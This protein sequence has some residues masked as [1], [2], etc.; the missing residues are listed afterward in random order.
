MNARSLMDLRSAASVP[1]G[2]YVLKM[3]GDEGRFGVESLDLRC[4]VVSG[5]DDTDDARKQPLTAQRARPT[6]VQRVPETTATTNG[7]PAP[8]HLSPHTGQNSTEFLEKTR[9]FGR[10]RAAQSGPDPV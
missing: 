2:D 3:S 10:G 6:T 1:V 9:R 7:R 8:H 4:L 5:A